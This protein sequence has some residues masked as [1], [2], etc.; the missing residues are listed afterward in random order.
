MS[1]ANDS[2]G[3]LSFRDPAANWHV[4]T[5][6]FLHRRPPPA[7]KRLRDG[8][9]YQDGG[10]GKIPRRGRCEIDPAVSRKAQELLN[11]GKAT[12]AAAYDNLRKEVGANA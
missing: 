1:T 7:K 10:R 5:F 2:C 9:D 6:P 4:L 12:F 3:P 11:A 8:G